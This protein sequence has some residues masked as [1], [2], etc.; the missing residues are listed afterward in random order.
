MYAIEFEVARSELTTGDA[1]EVQSLHGDKPGCVAGG[2]YAI[3]GTYT[4]ASRADAELVAGSQ[5]KSVQ[6]GTGEFSLEL[7][8]DKDGPIDVSFMKAGGGSSAGGITIHC[9]KANKVQ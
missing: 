2:T 4:L 5:E 7:Q 1:I 9:T 6:R 8:L 3:A